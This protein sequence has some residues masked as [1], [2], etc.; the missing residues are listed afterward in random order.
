ME[1]LNGLLDGSMDN[2]KFEDKCRSI[3]GTQSYIL[4]TLDKLIF[5]LIKQLQLVAN[6]DVALKLLALNAYE[7]AGKAVELV[8]HAN[9]Y[10]VLHDEN[11]YHFEHKSNPS[12]LLIQL[13]EGGSV[14]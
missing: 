7:K 8:Y 4:F 3:I 5:K 11:I 13:M 12:E 6:D 1:V 14:K 2:S 9:S 10:M